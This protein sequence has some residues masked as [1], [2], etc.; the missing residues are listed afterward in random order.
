MELARNGGIRGRRKSVGLKRVFLS[1]VLMNERTY[2]ERKLVHHLS[3]FITNTSA[4]AN[5]GE[6]N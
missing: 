1:V 3:R 6:R 4:A 2:A 5:L